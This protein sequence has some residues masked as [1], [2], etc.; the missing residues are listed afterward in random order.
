MS[1]IDDG[2]EKYEFTVFETNQLNRREFG[3]QKFEPIEKMAGLLISLELN[4]SK[5]GLAG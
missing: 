1:R 4:W 5:N 3:H 2:L